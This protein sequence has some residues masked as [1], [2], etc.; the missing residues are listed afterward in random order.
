ME[1]LVDDETNDAYQR[2]LWVKKGKRNEMKIVKKDRLTS[3]HYNLTAT[4]RY[5]LPPSLSYF[6][7]LSL[8]LPRPLYLYLFLSLL[9]LFYVSFFVFVSSSLSLSL[10]LPRPLYLYLSLLLVF[11]VSFFLFVS[12]SLSSSLSLSLFTSSFFY[13]YLSPCF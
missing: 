3:L 2:L 11:Y 4:Q 5:F 9:L 1:N 8:S 12:R 7:S 10:S 6:L 13:L